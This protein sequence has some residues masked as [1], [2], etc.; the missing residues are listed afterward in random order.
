MEPG[1]EEGEVDL[2]PPPGE[3]R[4]EPP[5][6]GGRLLPCPFRDRDD[7]L[8]GPLVEDVGTRSSSDFTVREGLSAR[9]VPIPTITASL[10]AFSRST[11]ARSPCP[12]IRTCLLATEEIF[13]SA[14]MAMF[15]TV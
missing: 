9:T 6:P 14:L 3:D 13:P 4:G 1:H 7:P 15:T 2:L 5:E 12:L 8:P 10:P 11:R